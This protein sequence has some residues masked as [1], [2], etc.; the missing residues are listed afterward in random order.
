MSNVTPTP[1]AEMQQP[2]DSLEEMGSATQ[3]MLDAE[4]QKMENSTLG[5]LPDLGLEMTQL[6]QL[7]PGTP[8]T[9]QVTRISDEEVQEVG[10]TSPKRKRTVKRSMRDTL[11]TCTICKKKVSKIG[12]HLDKVHSSIAPARRKFLMSFYSTQ[13]ARSTVYQCVNCPLRLTNKQRHLINYPV[14][15]ILTVKNKKSDA[16]FPPEITEISEKSMMG[17][18]FSTVLDEYNEI[19][20]SFHDKDLSQFQ[21]NFIRAFILGTDHMKHAEMVNQTIRQYK[22][23]NE[24]T[25]NSVSKLIVVLRHF[26]KWVQRHRSRIMKVNFKT[27]TDELDEYEYRNKVNKRKETQKRK[28]ERFDG[29]PSFEELAFLAKNVEERIVQSVSGDFTYMEL[30]SMTILVT[31]VNS[32][33]RLGTVLNTKTEDFENMELGEVLRSYDHKTGHICENFSEK[34]PELAALVEQCHDLYQ[35]ETGKTKPT[36]LFPNKQGGDLTTTASIVKSTIEKF[37]GKQDFSFSPNAIRKVWE[38]YIKN[39]P[40]VLPDELKPAFRSNTGHSEATA[41]KHY[42]ADLQNETIKL[43]LQK[44]RQ[45][46]R[47][48]VYAS[49]SQVHDPGEPGPSNREVHTDPKRSAAPTLLYTKGS[50]FTETPSTVHTEMIESTDRSV[51]L[52]SKDTKSTSTAQNDPNSSSDQSTI[53]SPMASTVGGSHEIPVSQ[54]H[55]KFGGVQ[56]DKWCEL[57]N[58]LLTF[59]GAQDPLRPTMKR[60]IKLICKEKTKLSKS[61]MR[62]VLQK[63]KLNKKDE[64][65]VLNKVYTKYHNLVMKIGL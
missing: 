17:F 45:I 49:E 21:R 42:V 26:I 50:E 41:E 29:L 58:R 54:G 7:A 18:Q 39:N 61:D 6:G 5:N 4:I 27:I 37:I 28:K 30:V 9:T 1:V 13:N 22:E 46:I 51:T 65:V 14:H 12:Q 24:Y 20:N 47:D 15:I 64:D 38:T 60:A 62:I 57:H 35:K 11:R 34:T 63:L 10:K 43:F 44:Q 16:E 53:V 23:D 48:S 40:S 59:K 32:N 36:R 33:C 52:G 2:F 19:Y 56:T 3:E 31:L 8:T 55:S 25:H